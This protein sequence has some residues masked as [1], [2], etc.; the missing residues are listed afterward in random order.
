MKYV[1]SITD[2]ID[3]APDTET[4]E[5]LQNV[6]TIIA[7][8]IGSVPLARQVGVTWEHIDKPLPVART[9]MQ[10]ALIDAIEEHEPRAKFSGIEYDDDI[11]DAMEGILKPRVIVS[12]GEDEEDE[13]I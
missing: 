3:F 4:A 10:A 12:I 2:A 8:V 5:I 7:T 13:E 11:T 1:V 9:L 6:R